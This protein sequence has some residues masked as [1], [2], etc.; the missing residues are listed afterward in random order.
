MNS[1]KKACYVALTVDVDPDANSPVGGRPDAISRGQSG[2]VKTRAS[3]E[4]LRIIRN[5][6]HELSI[7]VCLFW[8]A[9]TL[10]LF[11]KLTPALLEDV[12]SEN[13]WEHALH[14]FRHEDFAGEVSGQPLGS[15]ETFRIL[16]K[17]TDIV[18]SLTKRNISAFRAPYCRL[19]EPVKNALIK[20]GFA[21]DASLTQ[22]LGTDSKLKPLCLATRDS[23]PLF[24]LPLCRGT[25]QSG[26]PISCYLWQLFEGNRQPD[27]YMYL[28][29]ET[30]RLCPGG[31][32]QIALHPWHLK[33][34]SKGEPTGKED[35]PFATI[36][37]Q[38][39]EGIKGLSTVRFTTPGKFLHRWHQTM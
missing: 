28:V 39:L 2:R 5:I 27:D 25:D 17:A 15:D 14:G 21:Y 29:E 12:L 7:P 38:L 3:R 19:T 22:T 18:T 11:N 37:Q 8:E 9:R 36:F 35:S 13:D 30:L 26:H 32:L 31:L 20:L 34:N 16:H 6:C 4:G 10:R 1:D 33:V 23:A 24:E